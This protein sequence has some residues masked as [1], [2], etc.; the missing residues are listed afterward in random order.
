[1]L[2]NRSAS[3]FA[4]PFSITSLQITDATHL[5]ARHNKINLML[6]T[7][8]AIDEQALAPRISDMR[9]FFRAAIPYVDTKSGIQQTQGHGLAH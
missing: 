5:S 9:E 4:E 8:S 1:M 6:L 2:I 7:N 3:W